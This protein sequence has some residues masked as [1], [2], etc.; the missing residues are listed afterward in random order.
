METAQQQQSIWGHLPLLVDSSSKESVEYILQALWRTRHTGL[1]SVDRTIIRDML[2]LPDDSHLDPLL[3]C[4]RML[5]RRCVYD[6]ISKDDI[7]KLFP[8]EV[9]PELQRLLTLLL[10]KFQREWREDVLNEQ[11]SLPRLKVMTCDV[12]NENV[13]SNNQFPVINLKLQGDNHPLSGETEI[14][15]Q[16]GKDALETMLKSM[17]SIRDQWSNGVDAPNVTSQQPDAGG[18]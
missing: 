3:L 9:L 4:L 17:Y 10:Q 12:V 7:Q 15:F 2:H 8:Q 18:T 13:D 1:D 14:K 6:K 5:I 16:L 11:V